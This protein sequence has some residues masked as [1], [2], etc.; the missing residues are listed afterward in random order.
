MFMQT[1][2]QSTYSTT[3]QPTAPRVPHAAYDVPLLNE[4]YP[5]HVCTRVGATVPVEQPR[6]E[7]YSDGT[8]CTYVVPPA[9]QKRTASVRTFSAGDSISQRLKNNITD[10][11]YS[12]NNILL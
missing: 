4:E 3:K 2:G 11:V 10:I 5:Y 9:S 6:V 1:R 8:T 7:L 12:N